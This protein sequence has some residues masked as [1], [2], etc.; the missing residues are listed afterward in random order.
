MTRLFAVFVAVLLSSLP[1]AAQSPNP[2][3]TTVKG[4]YDGAKRNL[5]EAADKMPESEYGFK[6]TPEV[7]SF[8]QLVGHIANGNYSYCAIGKGEKNPNAT[9]FEKLTAK[10]DLLKA[11][12]DSFT[13]CDGAYAAATDASLAEMVDLGREKRTRAFGFVF[14]V[15]HDNEHY[16]NIVTYMRLKGHVPPSTERAQ[17][18]RRPSGE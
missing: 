7:R 14:N 4:L 11:L 13:Y 1:A 17:Q 9:D 12:R 15:S 2:V 18:P 3:S 10:A 8:G 5:T 6:P 16:G